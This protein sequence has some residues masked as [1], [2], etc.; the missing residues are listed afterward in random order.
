MRV[1]A[2]LASSLLGPPPDLLV[3]YVAMAVSMWTAA[4]GRWTPGDAGGQLA[5]LQHGELVQL[6]MSNG[7]MII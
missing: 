1:I 6:L 5:R 7:I 4:V 3:S 2:L